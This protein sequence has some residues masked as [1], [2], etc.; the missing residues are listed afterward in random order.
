MFKNCSEK[1]QV[2]DWRYERFPFHSTLLNQEFYCGFFRPETKT[3]LTKT[4]YFLHGGDGDDREL[5]QAGLLPLLA[6]YLNQKGQK[7]LQIVFP[8]I[9]TSFLHAHPTIK[10]KSYSNYFLD[11]LL[12]ACEANTRTEPESR[13]LCGCSMGGQSAL[14]MFIRAMPLFGGV[15]AHFPT[16]INF[17]YND[18]QQQAAYALRQKVAAA[19]LTVLVEG[20][21]KE[22]VGFADFSNHDPLA[23]VQKTAPSLW[24]D[25]KIYFDVGG[26]DEF[27]LSEGVKVFH[28]LLEQKKIRHHYEFIPQGKHDSA[29]V[30]VQIQKMLNYL[31]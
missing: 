5:A 2:K 7:N 27:G 23:L 29:F 16:L 24:V 14:N 19:M 3:P 15:G 8:Y 20:F 30:Q 22:F 26:Q 25:K 28:E 13:F 21:Q 9:G 1:I 10:S 18:P 31:L 17:D 4:L 12:P 6:D 11:E